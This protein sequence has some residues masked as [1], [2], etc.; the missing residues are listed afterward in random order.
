MPP[1]PPPVSAVPVRGGGAA[2]ETAAAFGRANRLAAT[3]DPPLE[4]MIVGRGGGSLEDLGAFNEEVVVRAIHASTLPVVAAVGHETDIT[5][6]DLGAGMRAATPSPSLI[7]ISEP[8]RP[9][10][11]SYASFCLKK[12]K[13]TAHISHSS[14]VGHSTI[15]H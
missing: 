2:A 4:V 7:N 1:V 15:T 10:S 3:L 9:Y 5:L 11:N 12:K 13:K 8:T 6:A 14:H